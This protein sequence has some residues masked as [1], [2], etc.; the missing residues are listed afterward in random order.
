M[1]WAARSPVPGGHIRTGRLVLEP[2]AWR[3]MDDMARLKAD[4]GAFGM[5]LGGVRGRQ[6]AEMEMADD[7]A[8][9]ARNGVGIFAIREDG[10]FIGMTG[11]HERPDGRGLGLRFALWPWAAGRGLA[12]EAAWA[13]L[14]FAHDNGIRRIIAVARETNIASR[15]ILGGIGMTL[16]DSFMRDGH[17]MLVYESVREQRPDPLPPLPPRRPVRLVE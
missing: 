11:L 4:A 10:R 5:M 17:Q 9:W 2:I 14:N 3:D 16:C 7:L 1:G 8:C 15:T 12:S 6:Q 13:V